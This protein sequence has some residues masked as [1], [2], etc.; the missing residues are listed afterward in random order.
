M[1]R[2]RNHLRYRTRWTSEVVLKGCIEFRDLIFAKQFDRSVLRKF[3]F[4]PPSEHKLSLPHK[5]WSQIRHFLVTTGSIKPTYRTIKAR[6]VISV[7]RG[8]YSAY[9][10]SLPRAT[11]R[12]AKELFSQSG[13]A[14]F[15]RSSFP[16]GVSR[17]TSAMIERTLLT[18]IESPT[19]LESF[20]RLIAFFQSPISDR[21]RE[22]S[23]N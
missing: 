10:P 15:D 1:Q 8:I 17:S 23:R 7:P 5:G 2:F 18:L 9:R 13:V 11:W 14:A 16:S 19:S 6:G 12:I 21:N 3:R 4:R 20:H 22:N